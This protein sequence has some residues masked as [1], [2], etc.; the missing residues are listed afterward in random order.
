MRRMGRI[1]G[2]VAVNLALLA[3]A[4]A[5]LPLRPELVTRQLGRSF[6]AVL[7]FDAST[8]RSAGTRLISTFGPFGFVFYNVY[9][10]ETFAWLVA[11][12][13]FLASITCWAL[14]WIG[15]A[16]W[17]SP[18]GAALLLF[19]CGPLM[20][21]SDVWFLSLPLLAVFIELPA[22]EPPAL[23]RAAVG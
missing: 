16:A 7:H 23:L 8:G 10:P 12:R 22:R 4:G 6:S 17:E 15:Y 13:A 2:L 18:W 9:L 21:S 1:A 5:L 11:L 19:V 14:T 3:A 20:A